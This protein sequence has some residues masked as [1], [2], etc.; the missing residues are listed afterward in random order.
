M[1]EFDLERFQSRLAGS[2]GGRHRG[3]AQSSCGP[4]WRSAI[5]CSCA[6]S[7]RGS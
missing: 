7:P 1:S 2:L 4:W 6:R 3:S 5:R